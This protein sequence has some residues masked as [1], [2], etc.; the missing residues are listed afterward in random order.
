MAQK[1]DWATAVQ[2]VH[3]VPRTKVGL[4][5]AITTEPYIQMSCM[6]NQKKA[7]LVGD[8]FCMQS[9]LGGHGKIS[10]KTCF[11]Q[12]GMICQ[13]YGFNDWS[14]FLLP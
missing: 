11:I 10:P 3:N 8:I 14:S 7:E 5:I 9:F 6:S 12:V 1:P 4:Q 13:K 2:S